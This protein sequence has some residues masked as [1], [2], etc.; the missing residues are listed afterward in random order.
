[1]AAAFARKMALGAAER[2][3]SDPI[4]ASAVAVAAS[5]VAYLALSWAMSARDGPA[6][7]SEDQAALCKASLVRT[8]AGDVAVQRVQPSELSSAAHVLASALSADPL[9]RACSAQVRGAARATR[10]ATSRTP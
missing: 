1:M 10:R 2:V 7:M 6:Y 8:S 9:M 5:G 3:R 4:L